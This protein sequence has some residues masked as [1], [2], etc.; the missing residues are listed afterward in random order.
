MDKQYVSKYTYMKRWLSLTRSAGLAL[1]RSTQTAVV[2]NRVHASEMITNKH[3][4]LAWIHAFC[5][6]CCCRL[7]ARN[8]SK[9]T[10]GPTS[11]H[12]LCPHCPADDIALV[13]FEACPLST[14]T[15]RS[16]GTGWSHVTGRP[17][18]M[19]TV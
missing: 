17:C 16:S 19:R 3:N 2:R 12:C 13:H 10:Q 11:L 5:H 7:R 6:A 15:S 8:G 14:L 18:H 1:L 9:P 4:G